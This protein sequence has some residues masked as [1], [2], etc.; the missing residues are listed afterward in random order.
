M[1]KLFI[2]FI[3]LFAMLSLVSCKCTNDTPVLGETELNVENTVSAAREYMYLNYGD[4]Y[5]WYETT[6]LMKNFLDEENDGS[7]AA[8]TSVFQILAEVDSTAFDT[9]VF[10]FTTTEEESKMEVYHSFWVGD[11]VLNTEAIALTFEEAY[12]RVMESNFVKP[13][14]KYCVLRKEVAP[15]DCNPQYIFG[16]VKAQLYVDAVTGEVNDYNPAYKG[17]TMPLGEWP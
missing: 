16:N 10:I 13:H 5:R 8:I 11:C 7:V 14:S 15:V 4:N 17:F 6:V 2:A 12:N 9:E 1:K 3:T